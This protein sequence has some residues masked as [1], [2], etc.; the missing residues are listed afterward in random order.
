M[1]IR[2][3]PPVVIGSCI[4]RV[5]LDGLLVA[6]QGLLHL[7]KPFLH[8]SQGRIELRIGRFQ[9][10]RLLIIGLGLFILL[11]SLVS[12]CLLYTSRCV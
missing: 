1:C 2:D 12:A 6:L 9:L 8:I 3:S 5:D 7:S 4:I 11:Q 10:Q